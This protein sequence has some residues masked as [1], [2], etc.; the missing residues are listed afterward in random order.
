MTVHPGEGR[1]N[2]TN[3]HVEDQPVVPAHELGHQVGL[4]DE[5]VD[6]RVPDR[7]TPTSP[8]VAQDESLMGNFWRTD[9][10][11]N[12]VPAP[13][14]SLQPRHLDDISGRNRSAL[15]AEPATGSATG[16]AG[17]T[18][19]HAPDAPLPSGRAIYELLGVQPSVTRR[20][21]QHSFD[22]HA[23]QWFGRDVPRDTHMAQWQ[24]LVERASRSSQIVP[25][26]T[27]NTPSI[28]HLARLEGKYFVV[29]FSQETG[30][31]L[32]AFVP[33]QRQ[34]TQILSLL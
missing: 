28:A 9:P 34:L 4:R 8:G 3:W 19:S 13:E 10:E 25:W 1:S 27:G 26:R 6:P 32:T 7:A 30:E 33:N 20:G 11:G 14:T 16:E 31:L 23:A 17:A 15:D 21:L 2:L 24:Q 5:Y 12:V 29:Q 22:W 18:L